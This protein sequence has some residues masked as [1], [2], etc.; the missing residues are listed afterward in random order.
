MGFFDEMENELLGEQEKKKE[1]LNIKPKTSKAKVDLH[2]TIPKDIKEKLEA[3]A[4]QEHRSVAN[5][6]EIILEQGLNNS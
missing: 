5:M 2:V 3:R 1:K 4:K 6:L